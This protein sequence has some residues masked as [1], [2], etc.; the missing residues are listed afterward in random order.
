MKAKQKCVSFISVGAYLRYHEFEGGG[1]L[2]R[3]AEHERHLAYRDNRETAR[4][5]AGVD[6]SDVG[7]V[8]ARHVVVVER[9]A[10]LL[11]GKDGDLDRAVG[12]LGDILRPRLGGP[13]QRVRGRDPER[14]PEVDLLIRSEGGRRDSKQQSEG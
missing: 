12:V 13:G 1:S 14:E 5:I 10:E 4:L 6:V 2:A 11:R 9:L 7:N 3:V 8:V